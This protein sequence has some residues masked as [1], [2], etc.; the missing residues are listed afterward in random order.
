MVALRVFSGLASSPW[1]LVSAAAMAPMDSLERCIGRLHIHQVEADRTAFRPLSPN[2]VPHGFL[3]IFWYQFLEVRLGSF[4]LLV[5]GLV[6]RYTVANSAQELEV[7]IS[8]TRTASRRG[9]G[10]STPNGR[11]VS[12]F[13]T[14]RQNFFSA[15]I[16]RCWY[17]GSA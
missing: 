7:F 9:R 17:S 10:G 14:Q 3:G 1:A 11:G 4:V 6:R 16:S 5:A 8:T 13:C 12:P 15:V 2:S